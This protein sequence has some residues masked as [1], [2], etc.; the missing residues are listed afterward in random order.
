MPR[1]LIKR[2]P[3]VGRDHALGAGDCVVGR[4]PGV[5]FMLEDGNADFPYI[6]SDYH[7]C[8]MPAGGDTA[9][10]VFTGA[11]VLKDFEPGVRAFAVRNPNFF[12]SDRGHFDEVE[13]I[14]GLAG[15]SGEGMQPFDRWRELGRVAAHREPAV[16][17]GD[18]AFEGVGRRTADVDGWAF[19]TG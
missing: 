9:A 8:I 5:T 15:G 12:K 18:G 3:G 19:G 1:L 14:E 13:T 10:G 4:D 6:M 16:R 7:L 11:Y 2:G 17:V